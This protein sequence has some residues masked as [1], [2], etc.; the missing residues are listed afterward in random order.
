[1]SININLINMELQYLHVCILLSEWYY[2][3]NTMLILVVQFLLFSNLLTFKLKKMIYKLQY[4]NRKKEP[5]HLHTKGCF[6]IYHL[7]YLS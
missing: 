4:R 6:K 1:M 2:K 3:V 7:N 5:N